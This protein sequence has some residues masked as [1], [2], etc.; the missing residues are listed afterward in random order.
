MQAYNDVTE[1]LKQSHELLRCEV[2]R[3]HEELRQKNKEL[4][5]SERLAALGQMAAGV[6]HEIRNPLGGIGLYSSL[7]ERDLAGLPKPLELAQRIVSD[8]LAFAGDVEPR[9]DRAR[10]GAIVSSAVADAEPEAT[11]RGA[12]VLVDPALEHVEVCCDAGQ[13]ER[14]MLNLLLNA[15]AAAGN[16]GHVWIRWMIDAANPNFSSLVVED[17]GPGVDDVLGQRIF[18]PF[19]T[20]KDSGTG[21]GLAI[22]HRIAEAHGGR[23]AVGERPGGGASFALSLPMDLPASVKMSA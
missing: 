2:S 15:L 9:R 4:Q 14:A 6:A 19:F 11:L 16:D 21:L 22:V 1:R 10:L 20:T 8:I 3:L 13:I 17:D 7:L 12:E 23:V 5:R 18:N